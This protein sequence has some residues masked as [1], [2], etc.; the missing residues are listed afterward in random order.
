MSKK[1][2]TFKFRYY[3]LLV[4]ICLGVWVLQLVLPNLTEELALNPATFGERPW[5]L[6]TSMWAHALNPLHIFFNM[7]SLWYVGKAIETRYPGWWFLSTFL[8]GGLVGNLAWLLVG[9][10]ETVVGASGAIFALLGLAL[11]LTRFHWSVLILASLN[12]GLGFVVP[13]VAWQVHMGG[14]IVGILF[15]MY[16]ASVIRKSNARFEA[17]GATSFGEASH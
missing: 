16:F 17:A 9:P 4:L 13:N 11:P 1:S 12:L 2:T 14:F 3:H 7:L 6:F 15:G 10:A 8:V 5:T